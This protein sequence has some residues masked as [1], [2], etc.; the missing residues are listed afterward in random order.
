MNFIRKSGCGESFQ[1]LLWRESGRFRR[2]A[3]TPSSLT[4]LSE[5][6]RLQAEA[7]ARSPDNT[8]EEERIPTSVQP[9]S[10]FCFHS[11]PT[12]PSEL[13]MSGSFCRTLYP[14]TGEQHQQGLSFEAGE[15]VKV[16]QALPGGWW[17]GE[18]DGT[19]GWF[20]SSYVQVME[21]RPEPL[22]GTD[23][24]LTH[25]CRTLFTTLSNHTGLSEPG[26]VMENLVLA[27]WKHLDC[28]YRL[29]NQIQ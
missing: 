19:R 8:E 4:R 14:F 24:E 10:S 29:Q 9:R 3:L 12:F 15:V 18:K 5:E 7:E 25:S 17:E 16:V 22:L 23:L 21:V 1:L 20:P 28:A 6:T 11:E 13:E 27:K 26:P 2:T